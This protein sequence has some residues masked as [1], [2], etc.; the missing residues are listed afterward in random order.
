MSK[1]EDDIHAL[2]SHEPTPG[3]SHEQAEVIKEIK[4]P[5]ISNFSERLQFDSRIA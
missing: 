5:N 1:L 3:T 4:I 2:E